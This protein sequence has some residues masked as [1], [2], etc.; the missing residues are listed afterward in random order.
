MLMVS[1]ETVSFDVYTLDLMRC[2][3]LRGGETIGLRP[4]AFDV[5]RYLVEHAGRLVS[6]EELVGAVW[7]GISV[8]DD[9]VVQC[10]KDIREALS[11]DNHQIIQTVPRRGY[12]FAA[13]VGPSSIAVLPFADLSGD[14]ENSEYLGDGLAEELVN[15]LTQI[16]GLKV[17]SRSSSFR[18][19]GKAQDIRSIGKALNVTTILEGSVRRAGDQLRITA[20]LVSVD[21]GYH[22][23]SETYDRRL[24]DVLAIQEDIAR[25]IADRL[26]VR[27]RGDIPKP[28]ARRHTDNTEAYHLYLTGRYFWAKFTKN[29]IAK[30][31]ECWECAI[32]RDPTYP[33]PYAGLADAYYR[34]YLLGNIDPR[35]AFEKIESAARK[36][37]E[38]DETLAEAHVSLA[39]M[40]LHSDWDFSLVQR[41]L[42]RALVLNSTYAQAHHVYSHYWIARGNVEQSRIDSLRALNIDPTNLTLIAHLGWH[43]YHAGDYVRAIE[44]GQRVI[45]MDPSFILARRYLGQ[46]YALNRMYKEAIAE[47]EQLTSDGSPV[48]KGYL[49]LVLALSG[50]KQE[51]EAML[52]DL[53]S[54][55][56]E[57]YVSSY[58]LATIAL[59]LGDIDRAFAWLNDALD[60]RAWP[61][62]YLKLDP[63]LASIRDDRRFEMLLERLER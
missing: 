38:L 60:E 51:A 31:C 44:A 46:A 62:P 63:M 43:Y 41:E 35:R 29:G 26:Q 7:R 18:F 53:I 24:G 4:K 50:R 36:A 11:D 16:P 59:A 42:K 33:L 3:L 32:A 25:A 21:D 6:K 20:Q 28:K 40:K 52:A 39:N 61:M 14:S 15:T 56:T 54:E 9:S 37:L 58:H 19:R 8:T 13:R 49:G 12:L 48:A 34:S 22:L 2:A 27:P 5:L 10:V 1:S 23:W 30:A 17:T 55:S 47:F 57:R 45:E